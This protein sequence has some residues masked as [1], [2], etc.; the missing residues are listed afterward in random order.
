MPV[1][2][3]ATSCRGSRRWRR[4]AI[5]GS[6]VLHRRSERRAGR[7]ADRRHRRRAGELLARRAARHADR[8]HRLRHRCLPGPGQG[9]P[10]QRRRGGAGRGGRSQC[11]ARGPPGRTGGRP[12]AIGARRAGLHR[13]AALQSRAWLR[14]LRGRRG[15][16]P[17]RSA[18]DADGDRL[19]RRHLVRSAGRHAVR[20]ARRSG[21]SAL[22]GTIAGF[23][24]FVFLALLYF[25]GF[26]FWVQDVPRGGNFAG[27]VA[28]PRS[29]R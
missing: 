3:H 19:A 20:R 12:A 15:G 22:V 5:G 1:R 24:L 26:V 2:C 14:Q 9:R 10:R 25:I 21:S 28:L 29:R 4:S 11:V 13:P 7:R 6:A 17:D 18:G 16:H 23:A 27:A 8:G